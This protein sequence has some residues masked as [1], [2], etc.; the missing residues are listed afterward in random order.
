MRL[1]MRTDY[2]LRVLIYLSLERCG[3]GSGTIDEIADA[4]RISRSHLKKVVNEL[5]HHGVLETARG[6]AGGV[7][8]TRD[9]A[10]ISIGEI[11]R[12]VEKD[13]AVVECHDAA[14]EPDCAIAQVCNL[15]R[16]LRRAVDA[17]MFELDKATLADAVA[18]P[19]VVASIL[20][21]GAPGDGAQSASGQRR[22]IAVIPVDPSGP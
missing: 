16:V 3:Q 9:P 1:T 22:P 14:A 21:I 20:G 4:Y 10:S 2:A 18:A 13:F 6:R 12:M 5:A 19:S 8:L 15:K 7:R 11:V 17:F